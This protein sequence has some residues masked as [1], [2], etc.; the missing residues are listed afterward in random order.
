MIAVAMVAASWGGGARLVELVGTSPFFITPMS[1]VTLLV[2]MGT[3][4]DV[5]VPGTADSCFLDGGTGPSTNSFL[6]L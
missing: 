4:A 2:S 3:T 6:A 5:V 1:F